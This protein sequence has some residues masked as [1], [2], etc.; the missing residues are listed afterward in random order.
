MM[1]NM[2]QRRYTD[3]ERAACL[4]SLAANGGN[5]KKTARECGV[6][7]QTLQRWIEAVAQGAAH[8]AA[9]QK[10]PMAER[11]SEIMPAARRSLEEELERFARRGVR[12]ALGCVKDL[13]AKDTMIAVGVAIDKALLLRGVPP[14][15]QDEEP[16]REFVV[17]TIEEA[18]GILRLAEAGSLPPRP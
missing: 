17:D 12:H 18:A 11:V 6:P 2:A 14:P 1:I 10:R 7:R 5:V 15:S 4:A 8:C 16:V 3:E 13:N 9:P